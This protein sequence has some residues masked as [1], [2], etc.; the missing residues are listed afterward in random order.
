MSDNQEFVI[1]D[2][3]LT[4][5]VFPDGVTEIGWG[6]F[7]DC[8]GLTKIVFPDSLTSIGNGAFAGCTGLT[9]VV[10][11]KGLIVIWRGAFQGCTGLTQAVLPDSLTQIGDCAFQGCTGL[12]QVAIPEGVTELGESVFGG[13]TGLTGLTLPKSLRTLDGRFFA[14]FPDA[15]LY[16]AGERPRYWVEDGALMGP[17]QTLVRPLRDLNGAYTVPGGVRAIGPYAFYRTGVTEIHLPDS[18]TEIGEAAFFECSLTSVKLPDSVRSIGRAAFYRCTSLTQAELSNAMEEIPCTA[19]QACSDLTS[20]KWPVELKTIAEGAFRYCAQLREVTLPDSVEK[21]EPQAFAG[22]EH[23]ER[24]AL[25]SGLKQLLGGKEKASFGNTPALREVVIPGEALELL[26][27]DFDSEFSRRHDA[28]LLAPNLPLKQIPGG[29]LRRR[30]AVGFARLCAQNKPVRDSVRAEYRK[31]IRSQRSLLYFDALHAPELLHWMLQEKIIPLK[32]MESLLKQASGNLEAT[33][34]LLDYQERQFT[35]GEKQ[36]K[37][38]RDQQAEMDWLFSNVLAPDLAKKIWRYEKSKDGGLTL[39]GYK[40]EDSQILVPNAIGKNPVTAIGPY[41]FSPNAKPLLGLDRY[42]RSNQLTSVV[43]PETVTEIGEGAFEDCAVLTSVHLPSK[44]ARLP[45]GLFHGCAALT[46][47]TVEEGSPYYAGDG[48]ALFTAD[49]KVMLFCPAGKKGAYTVPETVERVADSAGP[50]AP[51]ESAFSGCAKLKSIAFPASLATLPPAPFSG[52]KALKEV[53]VAEGN[54][55]FRVADGVLFSADMTV[56]LYCP[57]AKAG[58]YTVPE[59]VREIAAQA[60]CRCNKLTRI[61]LP[62]GLERIGGGAFLGCG[63]L[64][65]MTIPGGVRRL[66]KA[67]FEGCRKMADITLPA[68]M[69][70]I[71]LYAFYGCSRNLVIHAPAG[72]RAERYAAERERYLYP[73]G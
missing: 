24:V 17:D 22:C 27:T 43:L 28:V 62:D 68:A 53:N 48:G 58:E 14:G 26:E 6:A 18:V 36:K 4:E 8:T 50:A 31:Y 55:A 25:P 40:G 9:Q 5:V 35:A 47:I 44:L 54:T 49:K 3:V 64:E 70:E 37:Q 42:F 32:D 71:D 52:C 72:S 23:L 2:G 45:Q 13:C 21:I 63:K 1:E 69:E 15:P 57:A 51:G 59:T 29:P 56:L 10:F 65:T 67:T 73:N 66:E 60:F 30:A 39:L 12:T 38:E 34:M 11:P 7:A 19:F 33:A 41:A 46:E 20:V 61:Y 16:F